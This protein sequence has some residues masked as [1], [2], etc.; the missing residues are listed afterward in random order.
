[1]LLAAVSLFVNGF[2]IY[3]AIQANIG[4]GPW[5]VLN[6]GVAK[7]FGVLYGTAS[8]TIAFGILIIDVFLREPIGLAMFIDAVV[9]GKTVDFFNYL[10]L[11][12]PCASLLT[13]VPMMLL[14]LVILA[15]TQYFYMSAALGCGPRDTL[16]VGLAKRARRIPI[17]AVSI[18][19]L[20]AATLVGWLL[21]GPVG[22][23]TLIFAFCMGPI[24]QFA[25]HTVRFD[26]TAI[27]HQHLL[28]S[29]RVFR[30]RQVT[31]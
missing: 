18:A 7:T 15:Y 20:S 19:L 4:V 31:S 28:E 6:L 10:D 26:A 29:L 24:M 8:V 5:E 16:L 27:R 9:V 21:G 13:G 14:G 12:Q 17:G 22:V 30:G 3:L 25:F 11:V 1:M 2:G 23:G